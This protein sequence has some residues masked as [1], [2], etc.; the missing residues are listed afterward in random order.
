MMMNLTIILIAVQNKCFYTCLCSHPSSS[1]APHRH[2]N[3]IW[4]CVLNVIKHELSDS[5]FS[6]ST[7]GEV[8]ESET[9]HTHTHACLWLQWI[10]VEEE[11]PA[12]ALNSEA[13]KQKTWWIFRHGERRLLMILRR[14]LKS[15]CCSFTHGESFAAWS[16]DVYPASSDV[17]VKC[18][19]TKICKK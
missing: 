16:E 1:S 7:R 10:N 12:C 19:V 5:C 11:S 3:D 14:N 17:W 8:H 18:Y 2:L 13:Q 6:F 9:S 4:R 15:T